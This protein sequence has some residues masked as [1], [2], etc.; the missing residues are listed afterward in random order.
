MYKIPRQRKLNA[1][2]QRRRM[3]C[4]EILSGADMT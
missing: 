4:D 2:V 1:A 3:N